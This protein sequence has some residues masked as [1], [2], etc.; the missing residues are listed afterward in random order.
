MTKATIREIL[1]LLAAID[2]P[3]SPMPPKARRRLQAYLRARH[4]AG[5]FQTAPK[6]RP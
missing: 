6:P 4:K 5:Q 1:L 2:A 3:P